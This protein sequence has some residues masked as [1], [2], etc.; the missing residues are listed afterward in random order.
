MIRIVPCKRLFSLL[1]LASSIGFVCVGCSGSAASP[2]KNS[3]SATLSAP[4]AHAQARHM[5]KSAPRESSCSVYSNPDYGVSFHYPRNYGLQEGT[6]TQTDA[7]PE[8]KTQE[9]W[10]AEQPGAIL[11]AFVVIPDDAYPNTTFVGGSLQFVVNKSITPESCGAALILQAEDPDG[12]IGMIKVH[13]VLF[14]WAEDV[15][16]ADATDYLERDY[17]AFSNGAC[18]EFFLRVNVGSDANDDGVRKADAQKVL[19]Q[20]EK[21]VSS[22]RLVPQPAISLPR[23]Q[24]L[25]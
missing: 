18:Y 12:P 25:E 22:F 24:S 1:L 16:T 3:K 23:K 6:Q 8:A 7:I 5:Q 13:D 15:R 17:A 9:Q 21:I 14:S 19:W 10:E 20:L 11:L 4:S 2:S